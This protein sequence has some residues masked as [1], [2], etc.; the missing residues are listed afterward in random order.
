MQLRLVFVLN[1]LHAEGISFTLYFSVFPQI[2]NRDL[3]RLLADHQAPVAMILRT[4][5]Q[6]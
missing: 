4:N 1:I 6:T 5:L 2:L 3:L